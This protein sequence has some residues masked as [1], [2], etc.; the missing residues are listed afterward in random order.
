MKLLQ[1]AEKKDEE[2]KN[3]LSQPPI[4]LEVFQPFFR[5]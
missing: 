5:K 2:E 1:A 3:V 4:V